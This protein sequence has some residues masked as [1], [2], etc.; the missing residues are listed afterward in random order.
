MESENE[1]LDHKGIFPLPHEDEQE[2]RERARDLLQHEYGKTH[3]LLQEIYAVDPSWV[4]VR[5]SNDEIYPWE[6]AVSFIEND[7]P[8]I[9]MRKALQ[10]TDRYFFF[11]AKQ[12]I[13]LHEYVHTVR[14]PLESE[15]YEDSSDWWGSGGDVCSRACAEIK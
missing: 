14:F 3:Y 1:Y 8:W 10:N 5:Y 6:A 7:C 15:K 4:E 2:W 11:Y 13:L 12:E 9:E